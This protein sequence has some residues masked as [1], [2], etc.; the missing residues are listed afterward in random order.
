MPP[1]FPGVVASP[2]HDLVMLPPLIFLLIHAG[3]RRIGKTAAT[4]AMSSTISR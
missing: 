1:Y 3:L 4:Y 2:V